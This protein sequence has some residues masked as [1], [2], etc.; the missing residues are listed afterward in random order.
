MHCATADARG[1]VHGDD[2]IPDLG[3]SLG[4]RGDEPAAGGRVR[5]EDDG[6]HQLA[7]VGDAD[8]FAPPG[9]DPF[10]PQELQYIHRVIRAVP[11]TGAM[12]IEA[13]EADIRGMST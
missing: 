6:M 1:V 8:P 5:S 2:L 9:A 13:A 12:E 3:R 11:E 4:H 7:M 10:S